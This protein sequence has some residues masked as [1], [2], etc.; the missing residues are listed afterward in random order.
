MLVEHTKGI[1]HLH[2]ITEFLFWR[3]LKSFL[4]RAIR[5]P[6]V[7]YFAGHG[8]RTL[9][10]FIDDKQ[11]GYLATSESKSGV[12]GSFTMDALNDF[13]SKSELGSLV[14]LL[15]CCHAGT[16]VEQRIEQQNLL[17]LTQS[18]IG[19]K[20]NYCLLAAC[21]DFERA[22]EGEKHGIFTAAVLQGLSEENDWAVDEEI[23][24]NSLFEF[25]SRKLRSS[26]QEPI[27]QTGPST[28][29][30]LVTLASRKKESQQQQDKFKVS[31]KD[32]LEKPFILPKK[33]ISQFTGRTEELKK[34]EL[35]L[36]NPNR[37]KTE[38]IVGISG[39]G[40]LGKSTLASRFASLYKNDFPDGIIGLPVDGK[41]IHEVARDF[42]RKGG[43]EIEEDEDFSPT[44]IM[45]E[46]FAN[47]R[48]LLIFDN[49]DNADLKVLHPGGLCSLIITTRDRSIHGSFSI[50]Q[51]AIIDLSVFPNDD[52]KEF[53]QVIIGKRIDKEPEAVDRILELTDNLPLALEI[54][55]CAL[56][57]EPEL[58][59]SRYVEYLEEE[60]DRLE[61]LK[62]GDD[63]ELNVTASIKVSLK[64]LET[65][66]I[67]L[68]ACLSV[69]ARDG[70]S[71]ET[72]TQAGG[73]LRHAESRRRLRK[74]H[75][76]SLLNSVGE[77]R[78]AFHTL[79][80]IYAQALAQEQNL[81]DSA[82]RRHAEYFLNFIQTNDVENPEVAEEIIEN[83]ED[84]LQAAQ[85]LRKHAVS[86][87][88]K[89]IAYQFALDLRPFLLRYGYSEQ[90]LDLM[91]GFQEWAEQLSD[92]YASVRF[93]IQQAK[94]LAIEDDFLEAE[95][96]LKNAQDI[97][98]RISDTLQ[99][100][101]SQLKQLNSLGGI[102]RKQG[103][104][105]E[106]IATFEHQLDIA[107]A[108][109]EQMQIAIGLTGLAAVLQ[110]QEKFEEAIA[111]L[112]RATAIYEILGDKEQTAIG[113]NRIGGLLERQGKL[114]EACAVFKRAIAIA[115]TI[116][117]KLSL[118]IG[119]NCLAGVL[120]KQDKIEEVI[121]TFECL[122]RVSET[123]DQWRVPITMNRLG[124]LLEEQGDFE[125]AINVLKRS[126]EIA[127]AL[128]E[129][130]QVSIALGS[131][132]EIYIQQNDLDAAVTAL[133]EKIILQ[134]TL[135]E[136]QQYLEVA[137]VRLRTICKECS[138][139]EQSIA[140]F[141]NYVEIAKK[142]NDK[143]NWA[144][145][146]HCLGT[147]L[148][149]KGD[150]E[151]AVITILR[152]IFIS[153]S[154]DDGK[155]SV[156][157]YSLLG[158]TIQLQNNKRR[159]IIN[160]KNELLNSQDI[161]MRMKPSSILHWLGK[162]FQNGKNFEDAIFTF[163]QSIAVSEILN[164]QDSLITTIKRLRE[165]LIQQ[166]RYES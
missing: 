39:G 3:C 14:M 76:F 137:W 160:I 117:S 68:F 128:G 45:Q 162:I 83:F 61:E 120:Q 111:A 17:R 24:S 133:H 96:V 132:S 66:D 157:G 98:E 29:I 89:E 16:L 99:R 58:S 57:Q 44:N 4:Q 8:F 161:N 33:D 165:L 92:W 123:T 129:Q 77:G 134:S 104:F 149:D 86:D 93:K 100:Q 115:E 19:E 112:N 37:D 135:D 155:Q 49:A 56:Q 65:P 32:N 118:I 147:A 21:R 102:L 106:A 40:G 55:G 5:Q 152:S 130:K 91:T 110:K 85:W 7:I 79:V 144:I 12:Q 15:D 105:E 13:I 22:R 47:R 27:Q 52:A 109:K 82:T 146:L 48:I 145:G 159:L 156:F 53:L 122:I 107:E 95:L 63:N 36:L 163:W 141:E 139:L 72:A 74:L 90:A 11:D 148:A 34:L 131:L 2:L 101:E 124:R 127:E 78:Y 138:N 87:Q 50:P 20:R 143:K 42:A 142:V 75:R 60:E 150:I 6:T 23:T 113:L 62:H 140:A 51:E 114:E 136:Q 10:K 30:P 153:K 84:I 28:L 25:V 103:K 18:I 38:N 69:C 41:K 158:K 88:Q 116:D 67:D 97:I 54:V 46:V 64:F 94:Y 70:F 59:L 80:R 43:R 164:D 125:R 119:L 108:S 151:A 71:L 166:N 126:I 154:I 81:W 1:F 31:S 35:Q 73:L 26:G 121:T 9:D